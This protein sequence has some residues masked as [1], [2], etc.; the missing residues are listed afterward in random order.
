MTPTPVH[1]A[2]IDDC[3]KALGFQRT[4]FSILP[5]TSL[6]F[7][8]S[9]HV[10]AYNDLRFAMQRGV[11]AVLIGE[12]G[13]GKTLVGRFVLRNLPD[14][15][16][17]ALLINPL[18]SYGE[19]LATIYRDFTGE[20][21][22]GS[23]SVGVVHDLLMAFAL[24][25]AERGEYLVVLVDEA[26]KLSAEALEGLR[27]LSNLETEQRKLISLV[28]IGQPELEK[29]LS[30]RAMRPLRERIGVWCRLSPLTRE[31]SAS[32]IKHRMLLA[33]TAG[34]VHFSPLAL[35]LVHHLT[36]GVPRRINLLCDRALLLAYATG[37]DRIGWSMV[38][39]TVDDLGPRRF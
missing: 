11:M 17:V 1:L 26:Q 8:N 23:D 21:S 28:L 29:T 5:D 24:K 15:V 31:D 20:K 37:Q 7:P 30:F 12:V 22:P 16:R 38:R 3:Y 19:I 9:Q 39:R 6:F 18:L 34:N 35:K 33:R 36:K 4:P 14:N 25:C 27:L 2:G 13:L 32:Y 10:T